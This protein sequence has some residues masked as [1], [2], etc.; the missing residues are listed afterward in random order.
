MV[1]LSVIRGGLPRLSHGRRRAVANDTPGHDSSSDHADVGARR[2]V[3][4]GASELSNDPI[5]RRRELLVVLELCAARERGA[6]ARLHGSV[7][8][9]SDQA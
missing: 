8:G 4:I 2:E 5:A 3:I 6:R 1:T 7:T 9:G